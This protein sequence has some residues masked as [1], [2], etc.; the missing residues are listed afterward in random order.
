VGVVLV[1][2]AELAGRKSQLPQTDHAKVV[3][4]PATLRDLRNAIAAMID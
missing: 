1:L 2:P 3:Q 4:M